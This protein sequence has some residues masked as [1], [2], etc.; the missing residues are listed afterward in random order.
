MSEENDCGSDGSRSCLGVHRRACCSFHPSR[1]SN[2]GLHPG[3]TSV[4]EVATFDAPG[5]GDTAIPFEVELDRMP[6]QPGS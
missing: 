6:R 3:L 2:G 5:I 1:S 4:A